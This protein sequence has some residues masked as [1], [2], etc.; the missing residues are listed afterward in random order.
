MHAHC[1]L[2]NT[3]GEELEQLYQ[4]RVRPLSEKV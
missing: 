4:A 1:L 3:P 2:H